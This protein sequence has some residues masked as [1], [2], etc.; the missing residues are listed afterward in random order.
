MDLDLNHLIFLLAAIILILLL[1]WS[2]KTSNN[3][4]PAESETIVD[5]EILNVALCD[6]SQLE[7]Q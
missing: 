2:S 7:N 6:L 1:G 4:N 3:G 5:I